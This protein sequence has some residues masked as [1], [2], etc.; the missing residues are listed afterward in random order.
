MGCAPSQASTAQE[1]ESAT[2]KKTGF[3]VLP[4]VTMIPG[5]EIKGYF[6]IQKVL[7]SGGSCRVLRVSKKSDKSQYAMKELVRDDDWNPIL[8]TKEIEILTHLS[9]HNNILQYKEA[10]INDTYFF[11]LTHLCTGGEL[12]ERVKKLKHFSEKQAAEVIQ[13][14]IGA[15]SYMH[16]KHIAHRDLKPENIV[17]KTP[18]PDSEIVLIDFG[19]AELIKSDRSVYSDFVGTP[20]YLAPESVRHRCGWELY[21]SDM[22]AIG[23]IT[24]VLLT[25]RP[26]FW[27]N[28]NREILNRIIKSDVRWPSSITLSTSCRQFVKQLLQKDGRRRLSARMALQHPWLTTEAQRHDDHLGAEFMRNLKK[29]Q[30]ACK[31][32]R[33]IISSIVR[34]MNDEDKQLIAQAFHAM[35][36]NGDGFVTKDEVVKYLLRTGDLNVAA[37]DQRAQ[38]LIVI[39]DQDGDGRIDLKEWLEGKTA[40]QLT[41]SSSVIEREFTKIA[42]SGSLGGDEE[43]KKTITIDE[44]KKSFA[45]LVND[46]DMNAVIDEIDENNDGELDFDEFQ[47]A[48][49]Q[50]TIRE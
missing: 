20:Y 4:S 10:Y 43:V 21:K 2:K 8:F 15:L 46:E 26:P 45:G 41:K 3:E 25:G 33:L 35:D 19:D 37:A 44:I 30:T 24:Y 32:K 48:M 13:S 9:G 1:I 22:W 50:Y 29:F 7:G 31:L 23:V 16:G 36:L 47:N 34:D 5:Q 14:V 49:K 17:Y 28:N 6:N 42:S 12:F 39:M 38:E 11:L 18:A 27:G 40:E